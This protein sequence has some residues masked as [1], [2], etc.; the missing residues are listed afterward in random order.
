MGDFV[1]ARNGKAQSAPSLFDLAEIPEGKSS[2]SKHTPVTDF[3]LYS[4]K[5]VAQDLSSCLTDWQ[6]FIQPPAYRALKEK[7]GKYA[8]ARRTIR[9]TR[10]AR[11][12]KGGK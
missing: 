8:S 5:S 7:P 3:A 9:K 10:Q 1:S 12:P 6:N 4:D 11:K 2:P